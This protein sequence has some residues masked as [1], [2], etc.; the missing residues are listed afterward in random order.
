MIF[1][2]ALL[3]FLSKCA[4]ETLFFVLVIIS[5]WRACWYIQ[6]KK[7]KGTCLHIKNLLITLTLTLIIQKTKTKTPHPI[8]LK[9]WG[10]ELNWKLEI[11][12]YSIRGKPPIHTHTLRSCQ[13][14]FQYYN[15]QFS[16]YI[17]PLWTYCFNFQVISKPSKKKQSLKNADCK[18]ILN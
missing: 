8:I 3:I 10:T 5:K 11:P 1:D 2:S 12:A 18:Y 13:W 14:P 7:N 15:L 4:F 6:L 9:K 17:H 16:W